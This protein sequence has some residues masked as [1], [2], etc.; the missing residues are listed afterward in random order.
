MHCENIQLAAGIRHSVPDVS[1][2]KFL[3]LHLTI[4]EHV[5]YFHLGVEGKFL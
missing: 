5:L 1:H 2:N 4:C 3:L